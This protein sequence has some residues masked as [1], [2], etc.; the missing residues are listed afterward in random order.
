MAIGRRVF[1]IK[2]E[3]KLKYIHNKVEY[4]PKY[5]VNKVFGES[6]HLSLEQLYK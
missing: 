1:N 4:K 2:N 3:L 5:Y 6:S